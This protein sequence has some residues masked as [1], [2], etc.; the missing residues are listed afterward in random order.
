ME[1][2]TCKQGVGGLQIGKRKVICIGWHKTGT[3]T[4]GDALLDL[5]YSVVGARLDLVDHLRAGDLESVFKVADTYV[6]LQD[7]PWNALFRELDQRYPGSKFI[8]TVR[9]ESKWLLSVEKH[10]G[11][12]YSA[13]REWLYGVGVFKGNERVYLTRYRKHYEDVKSY[14]RSR[15]NDLLIMDLSKGDDWRKLCSFLGCPIP[16]KRFPHSNK[17]RH[18]FTLVERLTDKL[19][20]ITPFWLRM[21]RIKLIRACGLPDPRYRFNNRLENEQARHREL[22][23]R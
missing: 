15:P 17:G 12:S 3:T 14:F 6:A 4:L 2:Q 21:F 22:E 16:K 5:G 9:D 18:N 10:F 8:L 19:R 23:E 13:M 20:V 1:V 11:A 7:V